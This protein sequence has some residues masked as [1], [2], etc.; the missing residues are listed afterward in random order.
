MEPIVFSIIIFGSISTA[1]GLIYLFVS[2]RLHYEKQYLY[3]GLFALF[4]GCYYFTEIWIFFR[5]IDQ[6]ILQR[7]LIFWAAL[8]Y[9]I[10]PW[11]IGEYTGRVNRNI[12]RILSS[13]FVIAYFLFLLIPEASSF[14]IIWQIV[15]HIGTFAIIG[16]GILRGLTF[17]NDK[18]GSGLLL[19]NSLLIMLALF[20]EEILYTYAG[21][22]VIPRNSGDFPPLDYYPMLFIVL[23]TIDLTNDML[24]RFRMER[25][26][27]LLM[28]NV[29]LI[30]VELNLD[31]SIM[32]A[33][34][35]FEKIS[36]YKLDQIRGENWFDLMIPE[37]IREEIR[38]IA[39]H[40]PESIFPKYKNAVQTSE[41][42]E[43]I[44]YWR[45]MQLTDEVGEPVSLLSV[46]MDVSREE[47]YLRDI[48]ELKLK[49]EAENLYLKEE[50][51][52]NFK[53]DK[54]I[55]T[56]DTLKYVLYRTEQA[57]PTDTTVLIEGETGVGKELIARAVHAASKRNK[58]PLV[59]VNCSAIH[60]NLIESELFGHEKGAFT[61]ADKMRRGRFE[62]AH[63]GTLFLDEIGELPLELQ[64]KLLRILEEGEFERLGSN[65][66]RKVDVRIIVATNRNLKEEVKRGNFRE[67]LYFRLN[68]F[69]ILVP[70]LRKRM[71]DLPLLV[72]FF[73]D[74]YNKRLGKSISTVKKYDLE[75]LKKYHWPGNIREL[76]NV[77]ERSM[78]NSSGT[79]L[80][81]DE[82]FIPLP[83]DE[84]G[85]RMQTL[86]TIER[87]HITAVLKSCNW[88]IE[89][90]KGA[91]G[92]LGLNPNTLRN[93]MSKLGI[94]RPN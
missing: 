58:F 51:V 72:E 27:S 77:V 36:G 54:I 59:K 5:N 22:S 26:W 78:I 23:M 20:L 84:I 64:T 12:Q 10:F 76:R 25:R 60:S 52:L 94:K 74:F 30:I 79:T 28:E 61:G 16:Y 55:G 66:T 83:T 69:Q 82:S 70:P 67:D 87:K 49:L 43:F 6:T 34:P 40:Q 75:L 19:L 53:F 35:Y 14:W 7:I 11:F 93:R 68:A 15:A 85:E 31:G 56:S 46:G 48:E 29:D 17:M 39:K 50:L 37:R 21:I 18:R 24:V 4:A 3:F 47:Q 91:A 63:E 73:V 2:Y 81:I 9:G 62:V 41:G 13:V 80:R 88:R 33:N 45:N 1:F 38:H 92:I 44:F 57:A 8:Y 42:E 86:E 71:E 90:A 65:E 32:Y 89:G